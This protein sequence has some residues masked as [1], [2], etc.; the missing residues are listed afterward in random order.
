[1]FISHFF[2]AQINELFFIIYI[3]KYYP[4]SLLPAEIITE[5]NIASHPSR[6]LYRELLADI[7]IE[8]TVHK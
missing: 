7:N 4:G 5:I 1:M 8:S 6:A 3:S 2:R